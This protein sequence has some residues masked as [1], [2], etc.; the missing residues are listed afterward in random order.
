MRCAAPSGDGEG[1][2]LSRRSYRFVI[3]VHVAASVAWLGLSLALLVLTSTVLTTTEATVQFAA[4]T[5]ASMLAS[6]IAVPIGATALVTGTVLMLGTRW[7]VRYRWVLVKLVAT[8]ATFTLTLVLLRPGLAQLAADVDPA[9]LLAV[10]SDVIAGPIVS[11][12]IYIGAIA[13][14]YVKPWGAAGKA[15][16]GPGRPA[17]SAREPARSSR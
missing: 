10:D 15:R 2:K 3:I 16:R 6:T 9:H 8:C 14:S 5:A 4:G 7:S 12:A 13:L 17:R 1:M 11:S